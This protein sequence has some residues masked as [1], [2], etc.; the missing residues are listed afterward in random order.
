VER[1][2]R[3]RGRPRRRASLAPAI[4]HYVR[5]ECRGGDDVPH[6]DLVEHLADRGAAR[7]QIDH[8]ID[9]CVDG[10]TSSNPTTVST[11]GNSPA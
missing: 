5:E 10:A 8:W 4:V 6:E 9:K 11:A 1:L 2:N 7:K 3:A